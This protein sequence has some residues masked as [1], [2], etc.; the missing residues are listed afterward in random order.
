MVFRTAVL[1]PAVL[2]SVRTA[3]IELQTSKSLHAD[4]DIRW[5]MHDDSN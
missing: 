3:K 5:A 2:K 4:T 1:W